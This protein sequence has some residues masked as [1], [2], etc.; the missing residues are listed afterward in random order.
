VRSHD[1]HG[2]RDAPAFFEVVLD[3][4]RINLPNDIKVTFFMFHA[5]YQTQKK[6]ILKLH[7]DESAA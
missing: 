6:R 1:P 3:Y 7:Y 4:F 2:L 5:W